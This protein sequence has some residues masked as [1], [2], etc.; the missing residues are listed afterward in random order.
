[1]T[2]HRFPVGGLHCTARR[3]SVSAAWRQSTACA[4]GL[5]K[6]P[7]MEG[8]R[9]GG[10]LRHPSP[11]S[12]RSPVAMHDEVQH[13]EE[14][15]SRYNV[16]LLLEQFDHLLNKKFAKM[17]GSLSRNGGIDALWRKMSKLKNYNRPCI[18]PESYVHE[19]RREERSRRGIR[20]RRRE[21]RRALGLCNSDYNDDGLNRWRKGGV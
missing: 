13:G 9:E 1:M 12:H 10:M 19:R 4:K 11:A 3:P 18:S 7:Q 17:Q 20:G 6:F 16:T 21:G 2:H 15:Q 5:S 8:G 14:G